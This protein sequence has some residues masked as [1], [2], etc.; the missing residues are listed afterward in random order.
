MGHIDKDFIERG[1]LARGKIIE[2][3]QWW[4]LSTGTQNQV[5]AVVCKLTVEGASTPRIPRT[6]NSTWPT[7][8]LFQRDGA[9][10]IGI[11]VPAEAVA[12]VSPGANLPAKRRGDIDDGVSIDWASALKDR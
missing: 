3:R 8:C 11:G 9:T 10:A 5:H 2:C 6:S 4:A 1:L 7:T 12:L